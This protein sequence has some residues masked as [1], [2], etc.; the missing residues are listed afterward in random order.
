MEV[1]VQPISKLIPINRE[2]QVGTEWWKLDDEM[3][4][5]SRFSQNILR[6]I[7][8]EYANE[9]VEDVIASQF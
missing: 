8:Y 1:K 6:D 3:L 2:K 7:Q 9:K 4:T 5:F